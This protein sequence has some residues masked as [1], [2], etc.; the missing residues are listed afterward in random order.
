MIL[1]KKNIYNKYGIADKEYRGKYV[2][3]RGRI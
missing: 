1:Q 3:Q 2:L